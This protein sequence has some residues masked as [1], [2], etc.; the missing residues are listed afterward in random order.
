[1]IE[2]VNYDQQRISSVWDTQDKKDK[3]YR[4]KSKQQNQRTRFTTLDNFSSHKILKAGK[5]K[6]TVE[7]KV[8]L[9]KSQIK[10]SIVTNEVCKIV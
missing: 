4:V 5:I 6:F 9:I 1:M 2:Y 7:S 3:V 8:K 10:F